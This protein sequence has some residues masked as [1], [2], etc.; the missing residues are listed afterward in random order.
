MKPLFWLLW[1]LVSLD[2][3][4]KSLAS[5]QEASPY[6]Y[7]CPVIA[8]NT[9]E[10]YLALSFDPSLQG[11]E[12]I[13]TESL[14]S[15]NSSI[16]DA[17]DVAAGCACD[18][19]GRRIVQTDV[20][21]PSNLQSMVNLSATD[22]RAIVRVT[23]E[24]TGNC[25]VA[26]DTVDQLTYAINAS[27][28]ESVCYDQ[29]RE[30]G[31]CC[32]VDEFT[33]AIG[34]V[35]TTA[36]PPASYPISAGAVQNRLQQDFPTLIA[37]EEVADPGVWETVVQYPVLMQGSGNS[38]RL[39]RDLQ[40]MCSD[41][42]TLYGIIQDSYNGLSFELCDPLERKITDGFVECNILPCQVENLVL[43]VVILTVSG[44]GAVPEDNVLFGRLPGEIRARRDRVRRRTETLAC[45]PNSEGTQEP[46]E[47]AFESSLSE[48]LSQS[49]LSTFIDRLEVLFE[50][51][52][53]CDEEAVAIYEEYGITFL[54]ER[55]PPC[56]NVRQINDKSERAR[57]LRRN[58]RS[59]CT[60]FP[61][62]FS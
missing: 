7:S 19:C 52:C 31:S 62:D 61:C 40:A 46:Y 26:I 3:V 58:P 55:Q 35:D 28:F 15:L 4:L 22:F 51:H 16:P 25:T 18:V 13:D 9:F 24:Q 56:R 5:L 54:P 33:E 2:I 29:F 43:A 11:S 47:E 36:Q 48:K 12:A 27:F 60:L 17:Y 42:E 45:S 38:N 21:V 39:R 50:P 59:I 8:E 49:S 14:L 1:W 6:T 32:C 10:T 20:V 30:G 53:S 23:V 34:N 57:T 37:L 41:P 44:T